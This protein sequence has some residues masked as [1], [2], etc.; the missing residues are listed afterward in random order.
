MGFIWKQDLPPSQLTVSFF[1]AIRAIIRRVSNGISFIQRHFVFRSITNAILLF[2]RSSLPAQYSTKVTVSRIRVD[3]QNR[4]TDPCREVRFDLKITSIFQAY[5]HTSVLHSNLCVR[6]TWRKLTNLETYERNSTKCFFLPSSTLTPV[7][8]RFFRNNPFDVPM[9][10]VHKMGQWRHDSPVPVI[11]WDL[12][13]AKVKK[14]RERLFTFAR[15]HS[16]LS[17]RALK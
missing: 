6:Q 7:T 4:K 5:E 17:D 1:S 11:F 14:I 3:E 13:S 16:S 8:S 12:D 15:S 9:Y 2:L 10:G